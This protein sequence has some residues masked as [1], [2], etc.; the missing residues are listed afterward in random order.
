MRLL[1]IR[2]PQAYTNEHYSNEFSANQN[3]GSRLDLE[4]RFALIL[5]TQVITRVAINPYRCYNSR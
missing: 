2:D 5:T 1:D 4:V 3:A